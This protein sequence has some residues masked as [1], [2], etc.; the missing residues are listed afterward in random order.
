MHKS[1]S[2]TII[3]KPAIVI[4]LDDTLVHVT[5]LPPSE[6]KLKN[7]FSI[8]LKK[9]QFYVQK[10]PYLEYF[11]DQMSR[12]YDIY[13]FTS[14]EKE[15]AD[16]IID[17][18]MP[19]LKRNHR[20]YK[21]SCYSIYG[22]YVKD[23][24]LIRRSLNKTLLIDDSSGSSLKNPKNLIKVKPF[25]GECND[26]VLFNLVKL[27]QSITLEKDLRIAFLDAIKKVK[28]NGIGPF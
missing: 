16:L 7:Y 27:L 9:R 19:N 10:R 1:L 18:I 28:Y 25:C 14:S 24:Q 23:L 3:S 5:Q 8:Q 4:D 22:Y 17:N 20:F 21:D 13:I 12:L 26:R 6:S 2:S 15:Y 11:L